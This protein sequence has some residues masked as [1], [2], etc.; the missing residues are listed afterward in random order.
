MSCDTPCF[1]VLSRPGSV[2][3]QSQSISTSRTLPKTAS[4]SLLQ[5]VEDLP[6]SLPRVDSSLAHS[7]QVRR[8]ALLQQ[9]AHI[10]MEILHPQAQKFR[11]KIV[12]AT[13]PGNASSIGNDLHTTFHHFL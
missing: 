11:Y 9:A 6:P 13:T 3:H 5:R 2:C 7:L 8:A 10:T 1:W 4:P 12:R